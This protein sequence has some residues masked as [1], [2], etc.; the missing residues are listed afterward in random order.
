MRDVREEVV[1]AP[2]GFPQP[3]VRI[4]KRSGALFDG[5]LD[6]LGLLAYFLPHPGALQ[7]ERRLQREGAEGAQ[8]GLLTGL[9][10]GDEDPERGVGRSAQRQGEDVV[11]AERVDELLA[12]IAGGAAAE[13]R[14]QER[15]RLH[16]DHGLRRRDERREEG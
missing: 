14:A 7:S 11:G 15:P 10:P 2:V 9:R 6:D 4:G 8:V 12:R 13:E 16:V 3:L 1:L 5:A